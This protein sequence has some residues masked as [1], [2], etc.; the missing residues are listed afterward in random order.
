MS[1]NKKQKVCLLVTSQKCGHCVKMRNS[2]GKILPVNS[3]KG[4]YGM[5]GFDYDF[6]KNVITAKNKYDNHEWNFINVHFLENYTISSISIFKLRENY[7]KQVIY[8]SFS[9]NDEVMTLK[10]IHVVDGKQKI[11]AL[12]REKKVIQKPWKNVLKK[13][14]PNPETIAIRYVRYLPIF[15]YYLDNYRIKYMEKDGP[16]D[17]FYARGNNDIETSSTIP[18]HFSFKNQ[19][20]SDPITS[21]VHYDENIN[22]LSPLI[23]TIISSKYITAHNSKQR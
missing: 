3:E 13:Y 2:D 5:Y 17:H 23:K 1:L 7:V 6:V 14:I 22:E 11:K 4:V 21:L 15:I 20:P 12:S 16:Q 8:E 18:Y 19:G 9:S 10:E